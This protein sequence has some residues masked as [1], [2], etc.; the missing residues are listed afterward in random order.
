MIA[1]HENS[2]R[3]KSRNERRTA[4]SMPRVLEVGPTW[5]AYLAPQELGEDSIS[6]TSESTSAPLSVFLTK[7]RQKKL[8]YKGTSW[9]LEEFA[10]GTPEF[11]FGDEQQWNPRRISSTPVLEI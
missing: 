5:V 11:F 2:E 8:N 6:M 1:P 10:P 4:S 9:R 3:L 7:F